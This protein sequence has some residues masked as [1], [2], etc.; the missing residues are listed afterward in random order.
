MSGALMNSDA[1]E[2]ANIERLLS[3]K[4]AAVLEF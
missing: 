3:K 2:I 1:A 4:Y